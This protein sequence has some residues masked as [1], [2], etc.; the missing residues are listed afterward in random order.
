MKIDN[1][2]GQ[3][4]IILLLQF[5]QISGWC[6]TSS[7]FYQRDI[8]L[9]ISHKSSPHKCFKLRGYNECNNGVHSLISRV[10]EDVLPEATMQR[11]SVIDPKMYR[12]NLLLGTGFYF[13]SLRSASAT[14]DDLLKLETN[15][16][17]KLSV[18]KDPE[19]YDALVYTPILPSSSVKKYPLLFVLHGAA[20]NE[21]DVR[22]LAD[23]QGEHSGLPP[24][25]IASGQAPTEL[26]ENF[27]VVAPY[28]GQNKQSFYEEPRTKILKFLDWFI[29]QYNNDEKNQNVQIE[30]SRIFLLGFSDGATCGVE[31]MTTRKFA[32][33]I[34]AAYGFTGILPTRA[35]ERLESIPMW[36]FHSADDVIFPVSC[37]DRLVASLKSVNEKN[38]AGGDIIK[39]S[40]FDKDQEGFTGRVRGHS[41]GITA[42]KMPEIY[43]WLLTVS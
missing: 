37:S 20:K 8:S 27:I 5:L 3:T 6:I 25:L 16:K 24:S 12:R 9:N 29:H 41:T 14:S 7:F 28:A 4:I 36:V 26:T 2:I 18:V 40:R 42:S 33:G 19:T 21:R 1:I 38:D 43:K 11:V 35:L 32:A 15:Q 17:T 39:Y 34:I 13:S 30:K 10:I 31:L 22:N 23:I